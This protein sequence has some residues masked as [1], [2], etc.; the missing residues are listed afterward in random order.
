MAGILNWIMDSIR[1]Y[2][3]WSVVMGVMIESI[4]V[5]IPSPLIIMGAGF[6][7]VPP[8]PITASVF[9]QLF[10]KVVLP[11]AAASTVGSLLCYVPAYWGGKIVLS[12]F[13]RWFG[14]SWDDVVRIEHEMKTRG[15]EA[16][17]FFLRAIPVMPLSL[18]S[19]AAGVMTIPWRLFLTW[20]FLGSLPRCFLLAFL[21]WWI[22]D[23]YKLLGQKIDHWEGILSVGFI[24]LL[25]A[26]LWF[27]RQRVHRRLLDEG[28]KSA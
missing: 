10:F 9:S 16:S 20:T 2:G 1:H 28:K 6:I 15:I 11:G 5:P 24:V 26:G 18:I 23:T 7:L 14:F 22:G 13:Q 8:G 19:A 25:M 3:A 21:G 27:M 17:L 12:R 4:I